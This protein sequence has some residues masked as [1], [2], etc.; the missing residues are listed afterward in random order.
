M[1]LMMEKVLKAPSSRY[2]LPLLCPERALTF[3]PFDKALSTIIRIPVDYWASSE[4]SALKFHI[5]I[6]WNGRSTN[7]LK[8]IN[9]LSMGHS[10]W[11][12]YGSRAHHMLQLPSALFNSNYNV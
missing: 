1:L 2:F 9:D 12:W 11:E 5:L 10:G 4:E 3:P 6:G 7:A 8:L